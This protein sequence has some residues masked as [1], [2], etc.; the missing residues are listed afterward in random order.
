MFF[1]FPDKMNMNT[2][3]GVSVTTYST[4]FKPREALAAS[5][6]C[7]WLWLGGSWTR[8]LWSWSLPW[9]MAGRRHGQDGSCTTC[10]PSS[11][12]IMYKRSI[13]LSKQKATIELS[14]RSPAHR[15]SGGN[16]I[17]ILYIYILREELPGCAGYSMQMQDSQGES[18]KGEACAD[19]MTVSGEQAKKTYWVMSRMST[20][21]RSNSS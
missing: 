14:S 6:T 21:L 19:A 13:R 8:D 10:Q 9:H 16:R 3:K 7:K 5:A 20:V 17:S 11:K 4:T 2:S 1:Y 15:N 18:A 12:G